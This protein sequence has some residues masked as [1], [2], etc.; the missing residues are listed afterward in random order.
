MAYTNIPES[1]LSSSIGPIIG[2]MKG[3]LIAQVTVQVKEILDEFKQDTICQNE[4]IL[5]NI[6]TKKNNIK[7][8]VDKFSERTQKIASITSKLSAAITGIKILVQILKTLPIP[9][10]TPGVTLGTAITSADR[11]RTVREF[12]KQTEDDIKTI[13]NIV[14][15]AAGITAVIS[16]I[17]SQLDIIDTALARCRE[18]GSVNIDSLIREPLTVDQP[19]NRQSLSYRNDKGEFTFNIIEEDIDGLIRRQ[20]N[21]VSKRSG[22]V[23][24]IGEKSYSSSIDIL[25]QE[26]KFRLDTELS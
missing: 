19:S 4:N 9:T 22:R 20:V 14:T 2:S 15:G 21:A 12:I 26:I 8:N 6:A 23:V 1:T 25:V 24:I 18:E 3:L 16:G 13:R 5:S 17:L 7:R 10:S 11:L